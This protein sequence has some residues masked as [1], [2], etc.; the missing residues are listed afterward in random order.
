MKTKSLSFIDKKIDKR[1][2]LDIDDAFYVLDIE[3]VRRKYR[4]W[5][6]KIPQVQPFYAMKCNNDDVVLKTLAEMGAG[7]DCASKNEL[8]R[9]L[10]LGVEPERI[11]YAHTVKQVSHLKFAAEKNVRKVTF[12]SSGEL[13]KIK[14]FHPKAEVVLRIRF[15]AN[16]AIAN[17]GT[18]FGCD[19]NLEAPELIKMCKELNMNLIGI[20]FH[21]GSGNKDFKIYKS[22][23]KTVRDLFDFAAVEGMKLSFVDIGGGFM[24][25]EMCNLNCYA[26][27]VNAGI[28]KYFTDSSI[29][30]ISEPGR[31]FVESAFSLAVQVILKKVDKTGHVHY[32][33]NEGIHMSFMIS[34]L[35]KDRYSFSI[36]RKNPNVNGSEEKLSTIWGNSC[37]S[38]DKIIENRKLPDL[39]IGD[40]LVFHNMG[41]YT[42]SCT[43]TFNGFKVGEVLDYCTF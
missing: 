12:D 2:A 14:K 40:W 15:D 5:I 20:S 6:E 18:K 39:N 11:I 28:E 17:L 36:I 25:N 32:Y 27:S 33:I 38:K 34:H 23:L 13:M 10:N 43:S 26:E 3:D 16:N 37:D 42:L 7:F 24:D 35:Y 8:E 19:P 21:V 9:V 30:F 22:A 41:H 31:Y 1:L 29:K 4:N